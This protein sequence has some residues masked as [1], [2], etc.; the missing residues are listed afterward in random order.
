MTLTYQTFA[1]LMFNHTPRIV[2]SRH[3]VQYDPETRKLN[4][5]HRLVATLEVDPPYGVSP[6]NIPWEIASLW[7]IDGK[8]I[9]RFDESALNTILEA[10]TAE[11]D[12]G[13]NPNIA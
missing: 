4:P 3:G 10:I 7:V 6:D 12:N 13:T 1:K 9:I 8:E 5:E 2:P 11:K